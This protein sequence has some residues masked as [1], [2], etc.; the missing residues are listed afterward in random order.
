MV[1]PLSARQKTF[2]QHMAHGENQARA[3]VKMLL[4]QED[5]FDFFDAMA[6][7]GLFSHERAPTVVQAPEP[8]Y[9]QVPYWSMLDY[10][11]ACAKHAG[12]N[13]DR[14]LGDKVMNVVRSVGAAREP[15]GEIRDNY[16]T[17]RVF[18]EIMG[19]VPIQCVTEG[20]VDLVSTWLTSKFERGMVVYALG[21]GL[22]PKALKEDSAT[23]NGLIL[24]ALRAC[25]EIAWTDSGKSGQLPKRPVTSGEDYWLKQLIHRYAGAIG[26]SVGR[27]AAEL[28]VER[29]RLVFSDEYR[30]QTSYL[31]RPAVEDH[32]QNH[33]WEGPENAIVEGLRDVLLAWV[34]RDAEAARQF[35]AALLKDD[36]D[37]VR[38]IAVYV[39]DERWAVLK[40]LY[41]GFA[42]GD[43]FQ[44][45]IL[46]EL[47]MLLRHHFAEMDETQKKA[48]VSAIENLKLPQ[49][50]EEG[51]DIRR[52]LQLRWLSA[53]EGNGY[54]PADERF[55]KVTADKK[56]GVPDNPEFVL[57]MKVGSASGFS[58]FKAAELVAF[59]EQGTLIEVLNGAK[60]TDD[61]EGPTIRALG[62]ELEEA[63]LAKPELFLEQLPQILQ[64]NRASQ[65]SVFR[66]FQRLW[67]SSEPE[68]REFDIGS[69]WVGLINF[70]ERL[71]LDPAFWAEPSTRQI[72]LTPTR[73][74][75][76]PVV[77]ELL[78]S[79]TR[80]DEQ[81]IASDLLDRVFALIK[82]LLTKLELVDEVNDD[83]LT[84]AINTPRGKAVEAL[85]NCAL[86]RCRLADLS[87]EHQAAWA[88]M[89]PVFDEELA[90]CTG[91]NYEFS[92]LVANYI[93]NIQYLSDTWLRSNV[94]KIFPS[95]HRDN[96]FAA[97]EGLAYSPTSKPIYDL[98]AAEGIVEA[99][100]ASD[101]KGR[102]AHDK[103]I[104]RIALSYVWGDERID[105]PRLQML[106]ESHAVE[107]LGSIAEF[108][109]VVSRQGL[110]R[111][112]VERVL[113]Y[114]AT[115]MDFASH[116]I[117][118]PAGLLSKLS[119][120]A[121]YIT[122]IGPREKTLLLGVAP[123]ANHS[124]NADQLI[125]E[126]VRLV[127]VDPATIN[128]A[129]TLLLD[130][131][132]PTFDYEDRLKTLLLKFADKGMAA[133]ASLHANAL[134]SLPGMTEL[135]A[136][137]R[138]W[139]DN[140][141]AA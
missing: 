11:K 117:E 78:C 39:M 127:D 91:A 37:I 134:L 40:Q 84:Q 97:L 44:I 112:Q 98:L 80:N 41:V 93:V 6:E 85:F 52:R 75:I 92:A 88:A 20:D 102:H 42:S 55:A 51:D 19:F 83:P 5:F 130:A 73:D 59:A 116:L 66:G 86:R 54:A 60:Q 136:E 105:G 53:I 3:G 45:E 132:L 29:L 4:E 48:T 34:D 90:K 107:D 77:S 101:I 9:Y 71:L 30:L 122:S 13:D 7:I 94:H 95:N 8:G 10:L 96:F 18:T 14:E 131:R 100:L 47:Y 141:A 38:R 1:K 65:F 120:L 22:I 68:H 99:A 15:N 115:C 140:G 135:Y 108:F 106:F 111:E 87:G 113:A 121:C 133:E 114:W 123:F 31:R 64:A 33:S 89:Q 12:E 61:W 57:Y 79:G 32:T 138:D 137:L 62:Q 139:P 72:D 124:Y 23:S 56:L 50:K 17:F 70:M 128:Q 82:F 16:H 25:T 69:M 43:V 2:V 104:E 28:F 129:L 67:G 118:R 119:R 74:W 35:V 24:A 26:K 109:A 125:E 36:A 58:E 81:G 49:I 27:P 63:V 110:S 103:L 21:A 76:P 126:F 46:H